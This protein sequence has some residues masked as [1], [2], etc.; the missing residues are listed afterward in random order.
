[1]CLCVSVYDEGKLACSSLQKHAVAP[2]A[3]NLDKSEYEAF[4][5]G[6]AFLELLARGHT[7]DLMV[8]F[9]TNAF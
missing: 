5:V 9:S 1:M 7:I 4:S 8:L 3:V 6:I 2:F